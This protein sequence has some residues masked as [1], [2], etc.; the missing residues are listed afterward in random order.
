MTTHSTDLES[1]LS[2]PAAPGDLPGS[3]RRRGGRRDTKPPRSD[4]GTPAPA[5][6]NLLSPW[7]LDELRVRRLRFRFL[8]GFVALVVV[9]GLAW[10]GLQV[11][12]SRGQDSL[13]ADEG[14]AEALQ[15]QVADMAPV[16]GYAAAVAKRSRDVAT[17]MSPE[18]ELSR[19]LSGLGDA[20]P[21]GV[22]LESVDLLV[23]SG[24]DL[25]DGLGTPGEP[26]TAVDQQTSCPGP[27][28]FGARSIVGCVQL[29]GT[30]GSRE[31]VSRLVSTLAD[32]SFFIE[33]FITTTT[34][35]EEQ[36][37]FSGTVGL[38]PR[39][40]RNEYQDPT[41]EASAVTSGDTP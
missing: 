32:S 37:A 19:A 30:A 21:R 11:S 12:L 10:A 23:L 9:I 7:V 6:V 24:L 3:G 17:I 35:G 36:V 14:I 39:L 8:G 31:D 38:D 25:T 40:R 34:I 2:T 15:E 33:P 28:P 27:D 20:L 22:V 26:G 5:A 29:S 4:A 1:P 18:V 16:R 13:A 41:A